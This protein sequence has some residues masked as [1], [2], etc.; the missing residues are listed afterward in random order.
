MKPAVEQLQAA[1]PEVD[2]ALIRQHVDRLEDAYFDRFDLDQAAEHVRR[3]AALGRDRPVELIVEGEDPSALSVTILA[4]D[5]PSLFSLICGTLAGLG[6][7]ISAG[8]VFTY[9]PAT[10]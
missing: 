7:S 10:T 9:G 1:C 5:Y 6:F 2:P 8:D 4:Y 3:L